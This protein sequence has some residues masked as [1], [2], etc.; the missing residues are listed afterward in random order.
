MGK[1]VLLSGGL[2]LIVQWKMKYV[3]T[4]LCNFANCVL[5]HFLW[6]QSLVTA[7]CLLL[8]LMLIK[9]SRSQTRHLLNDLWKS[10]WGLEEV[11]GCCNGEARLCVQTKSTLSF[12][13]L[14]KWN[15]NMYFFSLFLL[16]LWSAILNLV[17]L[18][19]LLDSWKE[20]I[21]PIWYCWPNSEVDLVCIS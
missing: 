11:K 14:A 1:N 20:L 8:L 4:Q 9:Y 6:N 17:L 5:Y 7:S 15:V 13:F 16:I 12:L 19:V 10:T 2:D 18:K 3:W 21:L